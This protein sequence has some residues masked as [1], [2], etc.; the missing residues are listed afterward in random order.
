MTYG[1]FAG[2][3]SDLNLVVK[4]CL[5]NFNCLHKVSKS[6]IISYVT[7]VKLPVI[8]LTTLYQMEKNIFCMLDIHLAMLASSD[9]VRQN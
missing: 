8:L 1:T 7:I 5:P 3:P 4:N 9:A 6:D 2:L